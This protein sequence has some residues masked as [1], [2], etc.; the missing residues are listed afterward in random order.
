MQALMQWATQWQV[1]LAAIRDLERRLGIAPELHQLPDP[2]TGTSEAAVSA[3]AVRQARDFYGAYLWR[4]NSGGFTDEHGNHV[5]YGLGNISKQV[6]DVMK[7]PD[8]VGIWPLLVTQQHVGA[9]VGQFV[10][11]EMKEHGWRFT[12]RGRERAQMN[13]GELVLKLGGR[14]QFH[15]G[16]VLE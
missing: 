9:T 8:Y 15:S 3:E 11:I 2:S 13:F 6:N 14:F 4:N 5:R 12:G 1:P 7:T 16:G 10:G